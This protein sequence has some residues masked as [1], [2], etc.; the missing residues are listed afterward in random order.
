MLLTP[1]K[2]TEST[3]LLHWC[4]DAA[5][6]DCDIP[7]LGGWHSGYRWQW[8]LPEGHAHLS[9][10][11]LKIMAVLID[12]VVFARLVLRGFLA[13]AF[14]VMHIDASAS[15]TVLASGAAKSQPIQLV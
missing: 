15:V 7:G 8:I 10:P 1:W 3:Q 4:N 11:V 14:I 12:I 5:K 9:I 13:L 2:A 6:E